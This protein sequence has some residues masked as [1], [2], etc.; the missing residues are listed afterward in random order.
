MFVTLVIAAFFGYVILAA[1]FLVASS[2]RMGPRAKWL[3]LAAII[4]AAPLF[5]WFGGFG[6]QVETG[7][8]YSRINDYVARAVERTD[9]PKALAKEI[10]ALPFRGYETNCSEVEAAAGKLPNAAP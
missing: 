10:N 1:L 8:C 5:V 4:G 3:G 6:A 9:S 7:Q 2:S